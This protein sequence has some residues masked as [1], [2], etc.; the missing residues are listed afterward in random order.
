MNKWYR[1]NR[2]IFASKEKRHSQEKTSE[3]TEK[4]ETW[5]H[6]KQMN[7]GHRKSWDRSLKKSEQRFL[8]CHCRLIKVVVLDLEQE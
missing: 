7:R 1:A 4:R 8:S 3:L 2:Y 5:E 6:Y